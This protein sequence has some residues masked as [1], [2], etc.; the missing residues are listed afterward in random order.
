MVS[1]PHFRPL[2]NDREDPGG[3]RHAAQITVRVGRAQR[4]ARGFEA[5]PE[6]DCKYFA[7]KLIN[8]HF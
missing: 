2:G 8:A 5:V 1:P 6:Q 4:S 7:Q 3:G